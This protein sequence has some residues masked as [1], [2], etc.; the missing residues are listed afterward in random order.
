MLVERDLRWNYSFFSLYSKL[1]LIPVTFRLVILGELGGLME[2][3]GIS[4]WRR[5]GFKMTQTLF[6]CQTLFISFRTLECVAGAGGLFGDKNVDLDWDF[7]PINVMGGYLTY[8]A[9]THFIFVS[10]KELNRI[11]YNEIL[12]LRGKTG[13]GIITLIF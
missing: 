13:N 1:M 2:S 4:I 5:L 8:D 10:G 6:L 7:V 11:V 9:I 12:K 3:A